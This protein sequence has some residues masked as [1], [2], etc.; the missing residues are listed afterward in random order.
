MSL[1]TLFPQQVPTS[2]RAARIAIA[3]DVVKHV[4]SK[5][6]LATRGS[7]ISVQNAHE[8][9][10]GSFQD[11]AV[12]LCLPGNATVCSVCAIGAATMAAVGLFDDGIYLEGAWNTSRADQPDYHLNEYMIDSNPMFDVLGKWFTPEQLCLIECAFEAD[13]DGGST[14]QVEYDLRYEAAQ[15]RNR[16]EYSAEEA[17][18]DI[19]QNIVDND[20]LFIP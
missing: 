10:Q 6:L 9:I 1:R 3:K 8:D 12:S 14:E 15:Y 7:Y 4:D 18:R 19:F 2:P 13:E 17:L 11:I 20:G 16:E 5:H